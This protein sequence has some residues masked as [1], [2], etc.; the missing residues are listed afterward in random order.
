MYASINSVQQDRIALNATA[1]SHPPQTKISL[2]VL[3][4]FNSSD[5]MRRLTLCFG[6]AIAWQL[7]V[8][9]GY[10][11]GLKIGLRDLT[12]QFHSN[13]FLELNHWHRRT[14]TVYLEIN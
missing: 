1:F 2:P 6:K 3:S 13:E 8:A 12:L 9:R 5:L 4:V 14:H 11:A 10:Y 7:R